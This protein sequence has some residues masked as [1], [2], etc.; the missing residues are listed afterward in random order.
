MK[1]LTLT[2]YYL[3]RVRFLVILLLREAIYAGQNMGQEWERSQ[4]TGTA[5]PY[6]LSFT[7]KCTVSDI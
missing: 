4:K 6:R 5:F 7:R 3:S 2:G 1:K